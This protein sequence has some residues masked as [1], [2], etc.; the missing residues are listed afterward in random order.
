M[1]SNLFGVGL[2]TVSAIVIQVCKAIVLN[3]LPHDI[4]LPTEEEIL[5][6]IRD[7]FSIAHFNK[8]SEQLIDVISTFYSQMNTEK[9]TSTGMMFLQ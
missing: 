1:I 6:V 3:L 5:S 9:T 8:F 4:C 7:F 2:S